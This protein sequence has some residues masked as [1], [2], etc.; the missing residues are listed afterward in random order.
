MN[1]DG[2]IGRPIKGETAGGKNKGIVYKVFESLDKSGRN[3]SDKE[4]QII[5]NFMEVHKENV[6]DLVGGF[7]LD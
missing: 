1:L 7:A 4:F 6:R 3:L 5:C 2:L